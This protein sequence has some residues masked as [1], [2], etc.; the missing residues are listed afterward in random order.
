MV[1]FDK[2]I[3]KIMPPSVMKNDTYD[4]YSENG[5]YN[6]FLR[7]SDAHMLRAVE[8]SLRL[9]HPTENCAYCRT[10]AQF[11]DYCTKIQAFN[12]A[13]RSQLGRLVLDYQ[14]EI[15]NIS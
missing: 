13:T 14:A 6:M 1:K 2:D 15:N 10:E 7:N 9:K 5:V 3:W 11:H 12:L 4:Y 8:P